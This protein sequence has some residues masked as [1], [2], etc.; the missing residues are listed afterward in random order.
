M[1]PLAAAASALTLCLA[2]THHDG[3]AIR[4]LGQSRSMRLYG[5]DAPEMPGACRPGR[6]CTPGD[7]FAARDHLRDLTRGRKV[8]CKTVERDHYGRDVVRCSAD[9]V[10]L[11]CAMVADGYAA[12]RYGDL[13]CGGQGA[14]PTERPSSQAW[15]PRPLL[16]GALYLAVMN[17]VTYLCFRED[18]RRATRF[19]WRIRERHLLAL[20]AL[21]GSPAAIYAQ[22]TLR[23]KTTKQPFATQLLVIFG[24][25]IGVLAG[26]AIIAFD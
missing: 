25:H 3:D 15:P 6:R 23:H 22:Q 1:Q 2:P 9:G 12:K 16:A 11:S 5:I 24:L 20:A 17:A 18:K 7:P 21:G 8:L 26:L 19:Q 4:C 10:D 14:S 13:E